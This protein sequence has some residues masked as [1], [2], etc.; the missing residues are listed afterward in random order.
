MGP[1]IELAILNALQ[2]GKR[3]P[4]TLP[5]WAF[6]PLRHAL[7]EALASP[8]AEH[9]LR[10]VQALARSLESEM[11]S[12]GAAAALRELISETSPSV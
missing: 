11:G 2:S 5:R 3:E 7:A 4:Y 12:P 1:P 9:E 6:P 10:R 8:E